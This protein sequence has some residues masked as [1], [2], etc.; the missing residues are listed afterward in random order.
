[1]KTKLYNQSGEEIGTAQLPDEI[2]SVKIN[3]DLLH[4]AI[5]TFLANKRKPIA[6]AKD[7]SSVSGGG[8]K[9]WRQKG[10]GRARHGSIRSPIW[11]GGGVTHGPLKEK[12]YSKKMN[13]K[14]RRK[15]L[16]MALSSKVQ[17]DQLM[18]VDSINL[19]KG[20]TKLMAEI[21]NKLSEK[22]NNYKKNKKKQDSILVIQADSDKNLNKAIRNLSYAD[23]IQAD[24]LNVLEV[25]SKKYLII[26]KEAVDKLK[27]IKN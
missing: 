9:P 13:K 4:Q 24:N 26:L 3:N 21:L 1:M 10:T 2:F 14:A 7:R 22:L 11:K 20:K 8:R 15:A 19:E 12:D 17:D 5:I 23:T 27:K 6:Y 25:L 16:F 18:V